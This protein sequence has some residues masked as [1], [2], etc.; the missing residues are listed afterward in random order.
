VGEVEGEDAF[1]FRGALKHFWMAQD[2]STVD[3]SFPFL[4]VR[5][6][7]NDGVDRLLI[8]NSGIRLATKI[9]NLECAHLIAM[10]ERPK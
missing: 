4:P 10:G 6:T 8:A 5:H 3:F 7:R 1:L 9:L 2:S